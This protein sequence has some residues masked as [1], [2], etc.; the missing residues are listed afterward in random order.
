M[1]APQAPPLGASQVPSAWAAPWVLIMELRSRVL[2]DT[3]TYS[4]GGLLVSPSLC[5]LILST[6]NLEG[7]LGLPWPNLPPL[8]V[9]RRD[10]QR[11]P[12]DRHPLSALD[13]PFPHRVTG[14]LSPHSFPFPPCLNFLSSFPL[15]PFSFLVLIYLS[16]CLYRTHFLAQWPTLLPT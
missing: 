14:A 3:S 2:P 1:S 11:G 16:M 5:K 13:S 15:F 4:C 8:Q 7:N 12:E 9:G 6:G 10:L